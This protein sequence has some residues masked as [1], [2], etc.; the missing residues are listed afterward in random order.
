MVLVVMVLVLMVVMVLVVVSL[1]Q[2][3]QPTDDEDG[4]SSFPLVET[5][6]LLDEAGVQLPEHLA[7][8]LKVV[9]SL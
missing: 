6:L 3:V 2:E 1:Q 8:Q 9:T 4:S 5:V 7:A